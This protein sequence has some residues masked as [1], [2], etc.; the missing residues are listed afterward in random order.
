M[1]RGR[2]LSRAMAL[3]AAALAAWM[4]LG[5]GLPGQRDREPAPARQGPATPTFPH[6]EGSAPRPRHQTADRPS[7]LL[8]Q[9]VSPLGDGVPDAIVWDPRRPHEVVRSGADGRFEWPGIVSGGIELAAVANGFLQART[10][11]ATEP[12]VIVLQHGASLSGRV[13]DA[14]GRPLEDVMVVASPEW[15]RLAWPWFG[16]RYGAPRTDQVHGGWARS[17]GDGSFQIRGLMAGSTVVLAASKSG[18]MGRLAYT[19]ASVPTESVEVTMDRVWSLRVVI[20]DEETRE[21]VPVHRIDVT[22]PPD[23][24]LQFPPVLRILEAVR[25]GGVSPA[26]A[27]GDAFHWTQRPGGAAMQTASAIATVSAPGYESREERIELS[28]T[29]LTTRT[30]TLRR[31]TDGVGVVKFIASLANETRFSGALEV[32]VGTED[33]GSVGLVPVDFTGGLPSRLVTLPEGRYRVKPR[34]SGWSPTTKWLAPGGPPI[35]LDVRRGAEVECP[36]RVIGNPVR[37]RVVDDNNLQVHGFD[38][39]VTPE[40]GL[41]SGGMF[42]WDLNRIICDAAS[43]EDFQGGVDP[44]LWLPVGR[45]TISASLPGVGHAVG[46]VF[47]DGSGSEIPVVV[48]LV[49]GAR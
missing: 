28:P 4:I 21:E 48:K 47:A 33:H 1:K 9:V 13:V 15:N 6:L 23:C 16:G 46:Q 27:T 31:Q 40:K 38:L 44:M 2:G 12:L 42:R 7:T 41:V 49:P 43:L 11:V 24:D 17:A 34:G 32:L 8:G 30:I 35:V 25:A 10:G 22:H 3:L 20:Q 29:G 26:S 14:S 19:V 36:L 18:F 5:P 39:S 37:L 45:C